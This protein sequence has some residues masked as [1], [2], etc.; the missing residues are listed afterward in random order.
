MYFFHWRLMCSSTT[1]RLMNCP[2]T[3]DF[4]AANQADR[5]LNF[6]PPQGF[7]PEAKTRGGILGFPACIHIRNFK[8]YKESKY[9]K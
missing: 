8:M 2:W 5:R 1:F 9:C 4:L 7:D 6:L 3:K